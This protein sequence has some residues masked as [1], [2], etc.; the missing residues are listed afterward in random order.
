MAI[1]SEP[2]KRTRRDPEQARAN[3]LEAALRVFQTCLPD[4]VGLKEIAREAGVSHALVTHYFGT[5]ANLVETCL[6]HRF[7]MLRASLVTE[8]LTS[9]PDVHSMLAKYRG[10]VG[11]AAADPA[12]VRL[13]VWSALSG[14][15]DANDFFPHRQQGLKLLADTLEQLGG[16]DREDLE[17]C[18]VASFAL[19]VIWRFGGKA[20]AG[21]LGKKSA[22]ELEATFEQRSTD[23]IRA[24]L[25]RTSS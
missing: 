4:E 21:G 10:A 13:V 1:K 6:E 22:R 23:M 11:N 19:S 12:T 9:A 20:M 25:A 24:Y 16:Y 17:F 7:D 3:I 5:Y 2:K 15:A 18:L 8:L 14:R